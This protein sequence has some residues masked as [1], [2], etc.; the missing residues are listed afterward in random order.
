MYIHLTHITGNSITFPYG[1]FA[2]LAGIDGSAVVSFNG[3]QYPV[4]QSY[5]TICS[6]LFVVRMLQ[7]DPNVNN[8]DS[9]NRKLATRYII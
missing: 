9:E 2:V 7:L 8:L 4:T 6:V 5:E 1:Q 3:S